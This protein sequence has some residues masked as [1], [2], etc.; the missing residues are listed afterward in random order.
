MTATKSEQ[1]GTARSARNVVLVHGAFVDGS[2]WEGVYD[3]LKKD[4]Y[5]VA[6]VQNPTQ[7][8]EGDVAATRKAIDAQDGPVVLV[9]IPM[10]GRSSPKR[11]RT[12]K[13]R[14]WCTS[15]RSRRTRASR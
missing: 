15:R 8:L 9:G 7:P 10:A 14:R 11:A 5:N 6:V 3:L 4:G 13:W 12:R 2:T 1:T